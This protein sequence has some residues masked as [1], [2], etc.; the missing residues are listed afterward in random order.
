[1]KKFFFYAI[2][3]ALV[4][5]VPVGA[6]SGYFLY[7]K[8][9]FSYDYC[10][11]YGQIDSQTGWRLKSN[12]NSCLKLQNHLT[13]KVYFD[14]KI[15]TNTLGFRS[16]SPQTTLA[17]TR[18]IAAIGDSWTFGYG[19]DYE[20]SFPHF[21][22]KELGVATLNLGVPAYGSGSTLQ[23]FSRHFDTLKPSVVVH[24]TLGLW[25]RSICR[26]N[27]VEKT[28]LP[29]FWI[30][31][32]GDAQFSLPQVGLVED[33]AK[34]H[35]YPGGYLTSGYKF[36][37][38]FFILKPRE[39][40]QSISTYMAAISKR[41]GLTTPLENA[42]SSLS[43]EHT[44]KILELELRIY[45]NILANT[46]TLFVLDD[47]RGY[48][49][50]SLSEIKQALGRR[51]IYLGAQEWEADV[52]SRFKDLPDGEVTVPGDGHYAVG[53][54]RLI[55]KSLANALSDFRKQSTK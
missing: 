40:A 21:L 36:R 27:E 50:H 15:Y 32:H 25:T 46:D 9:T 18:P 10:E 19:V 20:E 38:M 42:N 22:E 12:A 1:M 4:I 16:A 11:P 39:I 52:A 24:F 51:F 3:I 53:A 45:K 8:L 37:E 29:C 31:Q 23:L 55:A 17:Q 5:V 14:T 33:A 48:Y 35:Q 13:G 49:V 26:A 41:I 28:L 54:N 2:M 6:V 7:R 34:E 44:R 30:D 47:P 43:D